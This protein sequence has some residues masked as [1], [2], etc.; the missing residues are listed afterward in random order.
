IV[1]YL[2]DIEGGISN[3]THLYRALET[4][5]SKILDDLKL[6]RRTLENVERAIN[7]IAS[8]E[9]IDALVDRRPVGMPDLTSLMSKSKEPVI[10]DLDYAAMRGSHYI[11]LNLITYELLR[12]LYIWKKAGEGLTT[13]TLVI[14]DEA[15]RFFPSEGTS[16]E[17][18]EILAD[19]ISRVARLGRA[20]GLGL[21]FSTHSPKD[22]HKIVLQLTNTKIIFRSEREFLEML[23]VPKELTKLMELIPDRVGMLRSSTIRAGHSIFMTCEPLL[24][25]FDMGRLSTK[26]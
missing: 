19:F 8:A 2:E 11:T 21:I 22:V 25:H 4:H 16:K 26:R 1:N 3:F 9:E 15:H 17:E 14:L 13:P 10:L 23:D 24:G 12:E 6:H 5:F 18:V 7:F 20:R